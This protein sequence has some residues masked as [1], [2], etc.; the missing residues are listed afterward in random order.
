M[1]IRGLAIPAVERDN[2]ARTAQT[3]KRGTLDRF[4][5][6]FAFYALI[7]GLAV[8]E[9]LGGFADFARRHR[10]RE[11]GVPTALL[12]LVVFAYICATWLDG[13]QSLRSA[14]LNFESLLAPILTATFYYL[15]AAMVFQRDDRST[16]GIDAYFT[17]RKGFV[18]GM[19]L[20]AE[21]CFTY[22]SLPYYHSHLTNRPAVFWYY[23]LPFKVLVLGSFSV[24]ILSR[25][26]RVDVAAMIFVLFLLVIPYWTR[27]GIQSWIHQQFDVPSV[28]TRAPV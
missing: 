21:L 2:C 16:Q 28:S 23:D 26:R 5:F 11:L 27:G 15:A 7:L 17:N 22:Q 18:A 10:I 25:R 4:S 13:W 1:T 24:L 6:I 20:G 8:T 19:L 9:V 12:A 3:T 14:D